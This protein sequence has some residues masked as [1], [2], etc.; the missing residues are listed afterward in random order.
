MA[1]EKDNEVVQ[2]VKKAIDQLGATSKE[3]YEEL[4]K[5]HEDLKGIVGAQGNKDPITQD[6]LTKLSDD[7][8][9]RQDTMDKANAAAQKRIDEL[10]T[11]MKRTPGSGDAA[12]KDVKKLEKGARELYVA[13]RASGD[14]VKYQQMKDFKPDIEAYEA[15][16]KSFSD[17]LRVDEKGMA[18]ENLKS[19]Q[20]GIDADGGYTVTPEI[21]NKIIGRVFESDPIRQLASVMSISTGALELME[22]VDEADADWESERVAN[23]ET[24][25]PQWKKKRIPVHVLSA[26]PRAT[27]ILLDDSG[28]NIESWLANKVA[29]KF[30]RS[31]GASFVTG[32]GVGKPT[33]FG[34]YSDW[35]AAGTYEY[36]KIER[37]NLGHATEFTTDGLITLKFRMVEYYLNRGTWLVNRLG[38]RDIMLLKDSDGQYIWRPGITVGEPSTLLGLP[39]RMSTTVATAAAS[40]IAIYLADWKE[41]YM[42]VDRQGINI[43]RDPYT[44]KPFVEFY[45]RK[46]VGG[47]VVNYQAI[48]LG[49]ISA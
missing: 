2:E 24:D 22:D 6:H 39:L 33:G 15:Y 30:A 13:N 49:V 10:E 9:T 17:Y 14:G 28:I 11:A 46:R 29:D 5:S 18:P 38:V 26:R 41:A 1:G 7:I 31:E 45:T 44:A 34:T 32:D 21:S 40:A 25:T 27:Q 47:D 36:G 48:K 37:Q 35:S 20:V 23:D 19:L 12:D 8:T 43:Q 3:N 42:I 4:R 16:C